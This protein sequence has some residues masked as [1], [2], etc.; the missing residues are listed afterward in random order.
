MLP[1]LLTFAAPLLAGPGED[2]FEA[3]IRPVLVE[4]CYSCH[5]AKLKSPF[6]GL[7][8]DNAASFRKG[9]D[10]GPAFRPGDASGALLLE[11]LRYTSL[12]I[13][14]PPT[15]KLPDTVI[16]DFE[17]WIRMGAPD[18]RAGAPAAE[19]KKPQMDLSEGRKWWALQPVRKPPVPAVRNLPWVKSPVDAFLLEKL[20]AKQLSPAAPADK[21]A[22][23]RRATFD[24]IGLPPTPAEVAEYL[25]D[26]SAKADERL[27]ERLLASPH[28]GERWA[29]HWLDLVRFAETNGHEFDN[30]KLDAWRYR[31]YV[32]RA[33]NEDVPYQ[34]M[35][36]EHLAGDQLPAKRVSR[37]GR[38]YESPLGTGYLWFGEVLNSATDSV[39]TRTDTV[40]NQI[41][42][43][44][45]AFLGLTVACARCH[46]HKFDPIPSADYYALFGIMESTRFSPV[47][48]TTTIED[49]KRMQ[50]LQSLKENVRKAIATNWNRDNQLTQPVNAF[51]HT[52]NP[53]AP[54]CT[55]IGDF[56]Q[57]SFGNWKADG[58]AFGTRTT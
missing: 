53:V 57:N 38:F 20:E 4:K 52:D 22:F 56:R 34:Q 2:F 45:K 16:A 31:D 39:K 26:T 8:L 21:R 29:R 1:L 5:N 17:A 19:T 13:K 44:A 12:R 7:V 49:E 37:D 55:I 25:N 35:I 36:L 3:K 15:G 42:V 48:A 32:I 43:T 41:D 18:P 33:F 10:S 30:D 50:D 23:I 54:P 40:D 46:D 47:S 11:A 9:G 27:I 51:F 28:Y 6:G 58:L 14:M 24:L